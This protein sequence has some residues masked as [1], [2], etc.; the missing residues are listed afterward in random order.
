LEAKLSS[1][2]KQVLLW[3]TII[4]S[5][6]L[7]VYFLQSKQEKNPQEISFDRMLAQI[8]NNEATEVN[9]KPSQI[10]LVDKNQNKFYAQLDASGAP[11]ETISKAADDAG[12]KVNLELSSRYPFWI[13]LLNA[14]PF[15]LLIGILAFPLWLLLKLLLPPR[16]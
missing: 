11:S 6:V 14:L 5:A 12:I 13:V 4:S 10:E 9:I 3:L 2:A 8:R 16:N 7:F 15:L 1:K